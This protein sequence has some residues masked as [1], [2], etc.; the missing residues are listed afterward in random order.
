[1]GGVVVMKRENDDAGGAGRVRIANLLNNDEAVGD[2][3]KPSWGSYQTQT[4]QHQSADV[5]NW[6]ASLTKFSPDTK[7]TATNR[8][9]SLSFTTAKLEADAERPPNAPARIA[10]TS[11]A[12]GAP[13]TENGL[14]SPGSTPPLPK[15]S[16]TETVSVPGDP[17]N[18]TTNGSPTISTAAQSS[19]PHT[20]NED[21]R[22]TVG[23]KRRPT[24]EQSAQ[25]PTEPE[26]PATPTTKVNG[27]GGDTTSKD[28]KRE[29]YKVKCQFCE[30]SFRLQCQLR[31]VAFLFRYIYSLRLPPRLHHDQ[32]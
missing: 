9:G 31:Y 13:P 4:T 19:V 23:R 10:S 6:S 1:M 5:D 15:E 30:S 11:A 8:T 27:K 25:P 26:P 14:A 12:A 17:Q 28:G 16:T 29:G 24:L 20:A 21:A 22:R 7:P 32:I 2:T 18:P 3:K